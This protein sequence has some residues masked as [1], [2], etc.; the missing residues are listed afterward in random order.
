[1]VPERFDASHRLAAEIMTL[2]CDQRCGPA[3]ME[4]MAALV[5]GALG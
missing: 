3:D 4:R 1:M 2:P 5:R